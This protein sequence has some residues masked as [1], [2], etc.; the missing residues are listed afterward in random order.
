MAAEPACRLVRPG[1]VAV[2]VPQLDAD[3]QAVV[4]HLGGP[5]LVLAGPGTGKT[6]TLVEAMVERIEQRGARP[7]QVLA[8]TFS[9]KAADQ[10]RNRV[11]ARLGRTTSATMAAT[12]HSFA[13]GLVRKYAPAEL[14]DAPLRLL[15]A[16]EQDVMLQD[17]LTGEFAVSWP[18]E[19]VR[20][21]GT[22]GFAREVQSVLS[23][24]R[25]KGLDP[26]DLVVLAR[27][28]EEPALAA[29]GLFM[30]RYLDVLDW[31][32][33]VDYPDLIRRAVAF[34]EANRADLRAA[35]T[36]VFV[37]EYQDTDPSQVAL[38]QALAGDGRN[39]VVVGDPHQS[40][41]AFRGAEVR[42]ILDFPQTFR[43]ASGQRAPV[44][45]LGATRRFGP[46][47]LRA[48]QQVAARLPL[49]GSIPA[50]ERAKFLSPTSV[51]DSAGR[52]DVATF[53]TDRAEVEHIADHLRRAHLH[54]G[55][56]WSEMAVLV[57]SG[58]ASIPGLRRALGAAG[59]PVEVAADDTPLVREPALAP[60]LAALRAVIAPDH[61]TAD[62]ARA[63]LL[64]PLG[65][66]DATELRQLARALRARDAVASAAQVGHRQNSA[67]L[68]RQAVVSPDRLADLSAHPDS[69]APG[70]S[71][72]WQAAD[73]VVAKAVRLQE[74]IA[75]A[76]NV[77][78]SGGSVEEVLWALWSQTAWPSR[79]RSAALG[80]GPSA[81]LA[82]RDLDAIC[83][84]FEMAARAEEQRGHTSVAS[85]LD[86][87]VAQRI[88][89]D[90]LAD[91]GVRG[92]AVRLLT[93][94]RAK[95]LEWDL[96]VVAHV[97]EEGWPDLRRRATL[98]QA[99]RLGADGWQDPVTTR[100][101][102]AEE[103]RLFYVACTR[104]RERLL[105]TAVAASDDDGE[106]PSRFIGELG[107]SPEA[108]PGR[109]RRPLS[110]DGLVAELRRTT[111][112]PDADPALREA[113][114]QRLAGL[115]LETAGGRPI[116]PTADPG[117]WWGIRSLSL[118]E[119]T[120][121]P[122]DHPIGLRASALESLLTCSLKWFLEREAGGA[123][124]SNSGQ[125]FGLIVHALAHRMVLGDVPATTE[126]I[127]ELMG[128][129]E[130]IWGEL[131]FDTPWKSEREREQIRLAL[132]RLVR[133]HQDPTRQRQVIATEA[134]L[135][136]TVVI[137]GGEAVELR[138]R[139]DRLEQDADGN[140][141]VIDLKT[142]K[143][144]PSGPQVASHDQLG[145][146][147][148]VIDQG[149]AD[150][151]LG[152]PAAAGGAELVQLR[153][154]TGDV[155]KVQHQGALERDEDGRLWI[156]E[157]VRDAVRR[158][159]EEDFAATPGEHCKYCDFKA[160]CPAQ[161]SGTVLS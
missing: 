97:Q 62:Q 18:P 55:V 112:D 119:R 44:Q 141:V 94:H 160:L 129:V 50:A 138:G 151:L 47:L 8:L 159:R 124:R 40:I 157:R 101:L 121:R 64:S 99:D 24:A 71:T 76:A 6:T 90:T 93:A 11:T 95:G 150:H 137:P 106:Q 37:D 128:H 25:E 72:P 49:T 79:L 75:S 30:Q 61:L 142:G 113:A 69:A 130:R 78:E 89:S 7:D 135:A 60:L 23:R 63:L 5:L 2:P 155:A 152:R 48:A 67:E 110:L 19:L 9:R 81:R 91:R 4:D 32:G 154:P 83:A 21:V 56:D 123:S 54:D 22:R 114:A 109:P 13:Y 16:A 107:V 14:Y 66:L 139:V 115:A 26:V 86:T 82:H 133:W 33:S 103:R 108:V 102:L 104:A 29:A 116:A 57:R 134:E 38:L 46:V 3:Q 125:G 143:K 41:Y 53:D 132:L 92:S 77:L 87:L 131:V 85:F 12:F 118:S 35:Y 73:R 27:E 36:C 88:P 68:L 17:L 147:Q 161:V 52:V 70:S 1:P 105:V 136:A 153:V 96:V 84:L 127:E 74:L 28:Q 145:F 58:R 31:T 120:V 65:G 59:V 140:V 45:V 100:E 122:S 15:S 111:T 98:L 10:L 43:T 126:G 156:E 144:H 117:T 148:L 39:L 42:G 34:A 146:Y 158:L 20:A 51:T 149:A 80:G